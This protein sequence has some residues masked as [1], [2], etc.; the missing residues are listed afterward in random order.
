LES[1]ARCDEADSGC[2][3]QPKTSMTGEKMQ[4]KLSKMAL[5]ASLAAAA[6]LSACGGGGGGG[7]ATSGTLGVSMT[8]APACGFDQVNV[9]VNKVRVN[10]SASASENDAGWTDI[11]LNPA[12]KINLLDLTNGTLTELGQTPLAAGHYTQVRLMLDPNNSNST[13]NSVVLT[14]NPAE[15]S[16]DTPSAIQTGI[17]IPVQF[18]VLA[19]QRADLVLDF[20]AC[21]S[22]VT[23]GNGK[24]ALKPVVKAIPTV[25]NGIDGFIDPALLSSH[26]MV[27]AQQNGVVVRSTVPNATTGEFFLARLDPGNYDLVLTADNKATG[28]IASVPVV[29]TTSTVV[30]SSSATPITLPADSTPRTIS[31]TALLNPVSSTEVAFVAAKQ[32]FAAGPTVTVKYQGADLSSGAYALTLPTA[33]PL[34]GTFGTLPITM[35]AAPA[36]AGKYSASASA[37]GYVTQTTAADIS[38]SSLVQNF[39]LVP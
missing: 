33:A 27:S 14:T 38:T 7:A 4:N 12:R 2:W 19:G 5:P 20:D 15:L 3:Y 9:T 24:Y 10:Q 13:A 17:K 25:L 29:S 31:G 6:M 1:S 21:K 22:I 35:T 16:L 8:D 23:K 34:L 11:T 36:L 37:L 28:V 39:T 30:V 18:D 26:V 32:S